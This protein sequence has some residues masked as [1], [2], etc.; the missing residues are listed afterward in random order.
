MSRFPG[1][2][3]QGLRGGLLWYD[4][5]LPQPQ[6]IVMELLRRARARGA[7]ALNYVE[8]TDFE[9]AEGEV[10]VRLRPSDDGTP[11][12]IRGRAVLNCA[13]PWAPRSRI[14][15]WRSRSTCSWIGLQGVPLR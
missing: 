13:G 5:F 12:V 15:A 1:V 14:A 10:L 2:R 9:A 4:G 8:V 7:V 6:R 3:K 11:G